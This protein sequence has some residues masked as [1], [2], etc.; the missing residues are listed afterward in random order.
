M[1]TYI[2]I[3]TDMYVCTSG[4]VHHIQTTITHLYTHAYSIFFW[5]TQTSVY[6]CMKIRIHECYIVFKRKWFNCRQV[7]WNEQ[8][9]HWTRKDMNK[10]FVISRSQFVT[11]YYSTLPKIIVFN[12]KTETHLYRIACLSACC[13]IE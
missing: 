9:L 2:R 4:S 13:N 12:K 1:R 5:R 8:F 10:N 11:P 3:H 7:E 6:V